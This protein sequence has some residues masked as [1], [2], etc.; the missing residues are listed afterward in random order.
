[1]KILLI[2]IIAIF[3][4]GRVVAQDYHFV[5]VLSRIVNLQHETNT[6]V[7]RYDSQAAGRRTILARY[8]TD[9]ISLSLYKNAYLLPKKSIVQLYLDSYP[10]QK[11]PMPGL[12]CF[13]FEGNNAIAHLALDLKGT[14]YRALRDLGQDRYSLDEQIC[15]YEQTT[16]HYGDK[17]KA[18]EIL[19]D[20]IRIAENLSLFT[21]V[22]K[23]G[24]KISSDE[25]TASILNNIPSNVSAA[26][27]SKF[28]LLSRPTWTKFSACI[29]GIGADRDNDFFGFA[30]FYPT[31]EDVAQ[32]SDGISKYLGEIEIFG[33]RFGS[34]YELD[35][36]EYRV[37]GNWLLG[38]VKQKNISENASRIWL[39]GI[40]SNK[41]LPI[42]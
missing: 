22:I 15:I 12:E 34:V 37:E 23:Q 14:I 2:V 29:Y 35:T 3:Q 18:V 31:A 39:S 25:E 30:L 27:I 9:D 40:E 19:N 33:V 13:V 38:T 20:Q 17:R 1:M 5:E 28:K 21:Y 7:S 4:A 36:L 32:L 6:V 26:L 11:I 10:R 42:F 24:W 16:S 8:I 41:S